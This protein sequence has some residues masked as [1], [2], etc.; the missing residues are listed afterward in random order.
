MSDETR[1]KVYDAAKRWVADAEQPLEEL[2]GAIKEHRTAERDE[3]KPTEPESTVSTQSD[4]DESSQPGTESS[5][6]TEAPADPP[7]A[8]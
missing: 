8:A 2:I 6:E 7:A 4:T 1:Q 3:A 5:G